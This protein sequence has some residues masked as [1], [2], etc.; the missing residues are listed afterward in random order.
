MYRLDPDLSVHTMLDSVG[1]P[2]GIG[3]NASNTLMYW[4]DSV[5][6][7][8]YAFDF[9]AETGEISGQREFWNAKTAGLPEVD[10]D[11]LVVDEED[12][13]WTALWKG[14][15]V[16]RINPE[17]TIVGELALPTAYVTCPL[18]IGK[19]LIVTTAGNPA[20]KEAGITRGGDV[21]RV[22]V[23]VGGVSKF[24]FKMLE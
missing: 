9:N 18:F 6:K 4:T 12:C 22:T 2:N 24:K 5:D 13:V 19:D 16:L 10:P 15:K 11:G 17:G 21:Y 20:E 3:W 23:G 8:I 14:Y 1:T 7:T